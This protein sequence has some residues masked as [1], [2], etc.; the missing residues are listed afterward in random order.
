MTLFHD[1]PPDVV[2]VV[3]RSANLTFLTTT[4]TASAGCIVNIQA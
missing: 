3:R 1:L 2:S 4:H